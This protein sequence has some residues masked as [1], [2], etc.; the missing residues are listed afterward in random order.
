M[1]VMGRKVYL[2]QDKKIGQLDL[3]E[4][5]SRSNVET[6][7]YHLGKNTYLENIRGCTT[8]H[9]FLVFS[10]D[11]VIRVRDTNKALLVL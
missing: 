1:C 2:L 10:T 3:V 5:Q 11:K 8:G 9:Y 7:D 4:R 6:K